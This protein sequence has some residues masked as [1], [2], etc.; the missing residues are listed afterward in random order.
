MKIP[1]KSIFISLQIN[2]SKLPKNI[3][4]KVINI[5][6]ISIL[7]I[8]KKIYYIFLENL[9]ETEKISERFKC[10]FLFNIS[11]DTKISIG[12]KINYIHKKFHCRGLCQGYRSY[13]FMYDNI[14]LQQHY[15]HAKKHTE[16]A[17]TGMGKRIQ[18]KK[19]RTIETKVFQNVRD[20]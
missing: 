12:R 10:Y 13:I 19:G 8:V 2:K 11:F 16:K 18:Y 6:T 1:Y 9:L 15:H 4:K 7:K 20:P 14:S 5:H 3:R 17:Q